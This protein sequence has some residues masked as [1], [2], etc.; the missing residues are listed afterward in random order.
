[1]TKLSEIRT[2]VIGVGSMGQN[3]ARV[4]NEIS[5]L[6]GTYDLD[7]TQNS[8]ISSR[9]GVKAFKHLDEFFSEV[10]AITIAVPTIYHKEIALM[11]LERGVHVLVEKPLTNTIAD[12]VEL[13][14]AFDKSSIKLAVGHIE[15]HNGVVKLTKEKLESGLWGDL[16]SITA[17]R[18]SNYPNRIS[19]VGVILDLSIHDIDVLN[20][21]IP[22]K[23]VYIF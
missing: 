14:E 23:Y 5:H 2:G 10:D 4:Y 20:Y 13:V 6:I 21:L 7:T 17:R 22:S 8:K 9:L 3:H 15:R 19:D 16:I 12:S 18:F 11:A 1:M